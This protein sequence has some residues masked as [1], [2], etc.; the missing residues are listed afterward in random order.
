MLVILNNNTDVTAMVTLS[1]K[2]EEIV[3]TFRG[4]QNALNWILDFVMLNVCYD[5]EEC[6]IRLHVGFYIMTMSIYHDVRHFNDYN[7]SIFRS[8]FEMLIN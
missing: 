7:V 6:D 5:N 4:S 2:R 3:V 1:K 8:S